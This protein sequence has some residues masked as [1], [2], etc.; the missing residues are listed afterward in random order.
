[1][2]ADTSQKGGYYSPWQTERQRGESRKLK[3][4]SVGNRRAN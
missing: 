1:M 4:N 3:C 2:S